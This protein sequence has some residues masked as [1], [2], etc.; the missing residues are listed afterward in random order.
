MKILLISDVHANIHALQAVAAAEP[1]VELTLFAGDMVDYGYFPH[2]VISWF[3]SRNCIAVAGNHDREVL[4]L[5]RTENRQPAPGEP[6]NF[7]Q[8]S[9]S[10][11]TPEDLEYL[12]SLPDEV[13]FTID[14]I[15]YYMTHYYGEGDECNDPVE[16]NF[17]KHQLIP[18]F[19]TIWREKFP[20]ALAGPRR[21]LLGHSHRGTL[22]R[23]G[24]Q[25]MIL[26]PGA[27]GYQL[28]AD[29]LFSSGADYIVIEDGDVRFC[30][31]E[32]DTAPIRHMLETVELCHSARR[33]AE[34]IFHTILYPDRREEELAAYLANFT[35]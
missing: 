13:T 23:R 6:P 7:A 29:C 12:V 19:E 18:V 2:E 10:V 11:M 22:F 34:G 28:G 14:G 3:R 9:L 31:V 5:S 20:D 32:Y 24:G 15:S 4:A 26:N 16:R 30:H 1:D 33:A 35:I 25:D 17:S 21:I 8:Y 27:V